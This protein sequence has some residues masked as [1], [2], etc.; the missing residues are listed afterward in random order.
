MD[1]PGALSFVRSNALVTKPFR[2][3][4]MK[5]AS[6]QLVTKLP[7][8]TSTNP[9]SPPASNEVVMYASSTEISLSSSSAAADV[10]FLKSLLLGPKR[11]C[12]NQ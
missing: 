4:G 12:M 1:A 10:N 3:T 7:A 11:G 9:K 6:P 2:P 8:V 5:V